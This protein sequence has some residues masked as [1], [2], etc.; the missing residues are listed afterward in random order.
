MTMKNLNKKSF[1]TLLVVLTVLS[2]SA[3]VEAA[4]K[5]GA[6]SGTGGSTGSLDVKASAQEALSLDFESMRV[7]FGFISPASSPYEIK[8]ALRITVRSNQ[9]WVLNAVANDDLRSGAG[10]IPV[11]QLKWKRTGTDYQSFSRTGSSI[12]AQ[13]TP[14][15]NEG[16]KLNYDML[17]LINWP[18]PPGTYSISITFTLSAKP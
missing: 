9:N 6:A 2:W 15:P 12:L 8:N 10:T 18:D 1:L 7:D 14:T 4:K 16:T 11:S 17:L 5:P 3:G 13:G